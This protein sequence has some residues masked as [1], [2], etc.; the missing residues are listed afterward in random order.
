MTEQRY[1]TGI[2]AR[3]VPNDIVQLMKDIAYRM[4]TKGYVL[5]SGAAKGSDTAF[6]TGCKLNGKYFYES[7]AGHIYLP[8]DKFRGRDHL[9]PEG[10]C[11]YF[12]NGNF[13]SKKAADLLESTSVCDFIH[14]TKARTYNFFTRNVYQVLGL[15]LDKS[16]KTVIYYAPEDE[17]GNC[18]GGTR[19]AVNLAEHYGIP[20]YNLLH[21]DRREKIKEIL[22]L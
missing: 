21:E 5:R 15:G 1:Y 18:L 3:D 4:T 19:I 7:W 6:E 2:G 16:S 11:R 20:T 8:T 22:E 10:N 17:E 14:K 12:A 9:I 13:H